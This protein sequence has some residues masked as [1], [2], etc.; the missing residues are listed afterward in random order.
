MSHG[1]VS[2]Q[3]VFEATEFER[4]VVDLVP[5]LTSPAHWAAFNAIRHL[6]AAYRL[7]ELDKNMALFRGVTAEEEAASAV[8]RSLKQ[9]RYPGSAQLDPRNHL[10]KHAVIP[11]FDGITRLLAAIRNPPELRFVIDD[12]YKTPRLVLEI[13][14]TSSASTGTDVWIRPQPPLDFTQSWSVDGGITY[15]VENFSRAFSRITTERAVKSTRD[16]LR[17]RAN[18]RNHL[19]YA[20][21]SGYPD[22]RGDVTPHLVQ[23][24]RNVFALIRMFLLIDPYRQHQQFVLQALRGF[25]FVVSELRSSE[26]SG[27]T[28]AT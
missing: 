22:F 14:A 13:Q 26:G 4:G 5:R 27:E 3:L 11:F 16:Y 2:D 1:R 17:R 20:S 24:K 23:Y 21:S 18:F 8:L 10:H 28:L 19:L 15:V 7:R 6:N 9:R 25:L 12:S